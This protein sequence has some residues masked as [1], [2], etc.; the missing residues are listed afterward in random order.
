MRVKSKVKKDKNNRLRRSTKIILTIVLICLFAISL[1][2]LVKNLLISSENINN[3]KEIYS[4]SN[5]FNYNYDV[6]LKD[7]PYTDTKI[8][9]M[10]TT[11]YVTDLID[12]I[13]LNL[14]YNYDSDV[15]SDIEY[16]YK[17]TSKLVGIY[18]SNGEEQNI[19]NKS[20]ILMDEQ[21]SKASG[22]GFNINEKIKLDL[23][24]ENELVKSFEQQLFMSIDARYIVTL[25]V[26]SETMIEEKLVKN[27]YQTT[28][29]IDLGSKTTSIKGDNNKDN[30]QYVTKDVIQTRSINKVEVS[31]GVVC[32][33]LAI[34]IFRK[35][36]KSETS[37]FIRND[38][39]IELNKILRL[40]QDKIVQV[41]NK[42]EVNQTNV[43]DVKDFGEIIKLSEELFKPI[44]Y[45]T[46]TEEDESWFCVVSNNVSYRY[47]LK[48]KG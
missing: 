2:T 28:V 22:N 7:N 27:N 37:R 33:I 45:W 15:S 19:W 16:T 24:K 32:F 35:L 23:K 14:N 6:V 5:K 42:I 9:G 31:I 40:C 47:I 38:Y 18:T 46:D 26:T 41:S 1:F 3:K 10:D 48:S 11:A 13:D 12:Y 20:Y 44:L 8:L 17:I 43:I 36:S 21:K 29:S 25:S 4:Y 30:R 34:I 39:R